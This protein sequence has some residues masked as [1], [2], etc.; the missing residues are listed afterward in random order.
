MHEMLHAMRHRG[1]DGAGL[2]VGNEIRKAPGLGELSTSGLKGK[3]ALG[4]VRLAITGGLDGMQ[5][6]QSR[7][8]RLSLLH[9]GEVYNHREL[10]ADL[11][12]ASLTTGSDSEVVMRLLEQE[13]EGH[14]EEAVRKVLPRLDG[15]YALAVTD[16][17]QTVLARDPVGVRQL[18]YYS[19]PGILAFASER[20]P[21]IALGGWEAK[22]KRLLPGHALIASRN[23][24]RIE[25]FHRLS[26]LRSPRRIQQLKT[27]LEAYRQV[28]ER[29]VAKRL[30]GRSRVGIIYSGGV[31]SV[32][33][34]QIAKQMHVSFTCYTAARNGDAPDLRWAKDTAEMLGFPLHTT[35]LSQQEIEALIPDIIRDIEDHSMNQVEVAIPIYA[36]VRAAQEAGER[37]VLTGQGADEL[38]GGYPW[39]PIIVDRE[40]YSE[41]ERRSWED[42][43]LLY[44]ECLEREDK[45]TMAHSLELRVPYLDPAVIGLA[46]SIAPPLKIRSGQD[47]LGKYVH[48]ECAL[49]LGIPHTIAYR[50]KEAA[51]HGANVHGAM[52]DM[53]R[54]AGVDEKRLKSAQYDPDRSVTE[55]LGSSSRY[56]YRYGREDLW[57]PLPQVQ[58]YLDAV[59]D[60]VD[61]LPPHARTH[62]RDVHQRLP[63]DARPEVI[64]P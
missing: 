3:V 27:A 47:T 60:H 43:C 30:E 63:E 13:Y 4:H 10:A 29:A 61:V 46:F 38:F 57:K 44:R 12:A 1:P 49:Q 14:L 53:A 20:K 36:A 2:V 51:Q 41:F 19:A 48:R 58:F 25:H 45:I 42:M 7:D 34:A 5:P 11:D 59:A 52:L 56:G 26:S 28:M 9:N 32:M 64:G 18:Y 35:V 15:V 39:Y 62:Y 37:V 22:I 16:Q 50:V 31:D 8:G 24:H 54:R 55:K 23:M 21:L 6:F 33:I 17:S 40:G